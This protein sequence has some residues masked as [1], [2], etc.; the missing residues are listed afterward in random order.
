[1]AKAKPQPKRNTRSTA[2]PAAKAA[3]KKRPA[4]A[5]PAPKKKPAAAKPAPKK[6]P[7]AAKPPPKKRPARKPSAKAPAPAA[8]PRKPS[9]RAREAEEA[10][11]ERLRK[12]ARTLGG[13][14]PPPPRTS[15]RPRKASAR[16]REAA[17]DVEEDEQPAPKKKVRKRATQWA[18]VPPVNIA[19]PRPPASRE[20]GYYKERA[21]QRLGELIPKEVEPPKEIKKYPVGPRREKV[22]TLS[23]LE[24]KG[25]VGVKKP[26][27]PK[28]WLAH[29]EDLVFDTVD[30]VV[31]AEPTFGMYLKNVDERCVVRGF[32]ENADAVDKLQCNDVLIAVGNIDARAV[33]FRA[34]LAKLEK[35]YDTGAAALR[36]ARPRLRSDLVFEARKFAAPAAAPAPAP[37]PAPAAEDDES[38]L[39]RPALLA[40][41]PGPARAAA[42]PVPAARGGPVAPVP[43]PAPA[44]LLPAIDEEEEAEL[45]CRP[46]KVGGG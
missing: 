30:V 13:D 2:K 38:F 35:C 45:V 15:S 5:K 24:A 17:E 39:D 6:K 28:S 22:L 32:V 26:I 11:A 44:A 19:A 33:G 3:P 40:P 21:L 8:R 10:P 41:A 16:A 7:A 18:G 14:A 29:D 27:L 9:A 43:G 20:K 37:A 25:L 4:A 1:M 23:D 31:K 42:A 12:A 36:V 46:R 34:T